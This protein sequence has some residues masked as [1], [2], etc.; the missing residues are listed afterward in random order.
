MGTNPPD[1]N[2][3][4]VAREEEPPPK[5]KKSQK[6]ADILSGIYCIALFAI[7][8]L[9]HTISDRH[10]VGEFLTIWPPVLYLVPSVVILGVFGWRNS[11]RLRIA[12][13][14][15][16]FL[17]SATLIEWRPLLRPSGGQG[18]LTIVTWNIGGGYASET[19]VLK[20]LEDLRPD[21]VFF[22]ESPDGADAFGELTRG[23]AFAGYRYYDSGDCATLSR[24]PCEVLE[25][26]PVG[27]WDT[28]QMLV[29]EIEGRRVLLVNVRLM[30][31]ALILNPFDA[32]S[33]EKLWRDNQSRR[34]QYPLLVELIE[35]AQSEH[36][37]EHVILAGDFN[38]EASAK[39]LNVIR[40]RFTDI[41]RV[42]GSGWG[43]TVTTQFPVARI[44]H[45]YVRHL[46][47][48]SV[49]VMQSPLSDHLPVVAT[50]RLEHPRSE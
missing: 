33:R 10:P 22:Q 4:S 39:S 41:W 3:T 36:Q 35:A 14:L 16:V 40:R 19:E 5:S 7:L 21:L 26:K 31:P 37:I 20:S 34:D 30:L 15:V 8:L 9:Y 50:L 44:D 24:W 6:Q 32:R 12:S 2:V 45:I 17:F 11:K 47:P 49:R 25:S 43:G 46:K 42:K 29:A 27:P 18:D 48:N 23:D 1:E 38:T 13:A 28:P